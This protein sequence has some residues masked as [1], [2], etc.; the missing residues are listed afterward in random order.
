MTSKRLQLCFDAD[1][2]RG[3]EDYPSN[4]NLLIVAVGCVILSLMFGLFVLRPRK[5]TK[6]IK[7]SINLKRL[8]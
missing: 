6:V 3:H 4:N 8:K 5:K 1:H 2:R 7:A